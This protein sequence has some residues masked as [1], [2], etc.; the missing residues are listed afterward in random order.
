MW[1]VGFC[2]VV[3]LFCSCLVGSRKFV[4]ERVFVL[5]LFVVTW[6]FCT[7]ARDQTQRLTYAK[8][9]NLEHC[10][11]APALRVPVI[12]QCY[13]RLLVG[14]EK[15]TAIWKSVC[16][17]SKTLTV[18]LGESQLYHS[19]CIPY[20]IYISMTQR[21]LLACVYC[22]T[23]INTEDTEPVSM[24]NNRWMG[25]SWRNESVSL[26]SLSIRCSLAT[27]A[28]IMPFPMCFRQWLSSGWCENKR[29]GDKKQ[30]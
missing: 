5:F 6:F 22:L 10:T 27:R 28:S 19:W 13:W 11:T 23:V 7:S 14:M 1:G 21:H 25:A 26:V 17:F 12:L 18:K 29:E 30:E 16:R 9:A 8:H 4:V 24:S 15:N 3:I 2:F 20:G